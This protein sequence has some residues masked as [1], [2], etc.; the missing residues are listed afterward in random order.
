MDLSELKEKLSSYKK[1]DIVFTK[2]AEIRALVRNINLEEVKENIV[3]PERLADFR[4]INNKFE[5]YFA[6][7]KTYCHKYILKL[8]GKVIIV[9]IISINRDWQRT[10]R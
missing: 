6:Y 9:T 3:N 1:E 8:N 10:L 7:S 4:E 2:H 5:C